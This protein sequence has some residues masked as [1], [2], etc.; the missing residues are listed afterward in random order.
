MEISIYFNWIDGKNYCVNMNNTELI[1]TLKLKLVQ[2]VLDDSN[3][4]GIFDDL[5]FIYSGKQLQ[6]TA[7]ICDTGIENNATVHCVL[8]L[9]GAGEDDTS[10]VNSRLL[11]IDSF[12]A[13]GLAPA[14]IRF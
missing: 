2:K 6:D 8:R 9:R 12:G 7:R 3:A 14:P 11:P 13:T 4:I 10:L 1:L 5:R